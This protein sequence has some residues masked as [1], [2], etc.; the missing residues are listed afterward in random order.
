MMVLNED[1]LQINICPHM[2]QKYIFKDV[3][4]F[5]IELNDMCAFDFLLLMYLSAGTRKGYNC[6]HFTCKMVKH[7]PFRYIHEKKTNKWH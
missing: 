2:Y 7:K 3:K 6:D 5:V 4:H 1:E